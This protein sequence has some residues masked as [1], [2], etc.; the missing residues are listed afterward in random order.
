MDNKSDIIFGIKKSLEQKISNQLERN[1]NAGHPIS[2]Q[3]AMDMVLENQQRELKLSADK[4][5][6]EGNEDAAEF[7]R[8]L[9]ELLPG[10]MREFSLH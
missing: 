1:A 7:L 10:L 9:A 8:N 4:Y 3:K 5:E 2:R 6:R